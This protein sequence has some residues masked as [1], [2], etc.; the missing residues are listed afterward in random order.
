M[1]VICLDASDWQTQ[2]DFYS[3]LLPQLG[4]PEWHGR[5]L[6]ALE[7]SL[8]GGINELAPPFKVQVER[9]NSLP[10]AMRQF[11]SKVASVFDDVRSEKLHDVAF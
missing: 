8:R 11:L 7:D 3:A 10:D 6:D 5:N 9:A 1:K 4:A 2:E